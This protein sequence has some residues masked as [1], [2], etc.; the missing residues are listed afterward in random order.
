MTE[1]TSEAEK[2]RDQ[3]LARQRR[4]LFG[5]DVNPEEVIDDIRRHFDEELKGL[6]VV[7]RT[8][9]QRTIR[10]FEPQ[11]PIFPSEGPAQ[12]TGL[13]DHN[14]PGI[15]LI[16]FG[17]V[18]P[19]IC[20]LIELTIHFCAGVFFDPIPSWWH[21]ALVIF[22]P[23]GNALHI[24]RLRLGGGPSAGLALGFNAASL[25]IASFYAT[26]YAPLLLPGLLA[27]LYFGIG[28]LPLGPLFAL[29]TAYLLRRRLKTH[30]TISSAAQLKATLAGTT[31]AIIALGALEFRPA[32]TRVALEWADDVAPRRQQHG[33]QILRSV[34]DEETM[35]RACYERPRRFTNLA[36]LF[37]SRDNPLQ[38]LEARTIYFRVTGK[39]FNSQ[40]PPRLYTR[41]GRWEIAEEFSWESDDAQGGNAVEGRLRGLSLEDSRIDARIHSQAGLAYLEWTLQFRNHSNR[42]QEARTQ[43]LL[44]PDGL[45]SRLTLWINGEERE[46][47][48]AGRGHVRQAYENIVRQR[49]DPVLVTTQGKDRIL[50]QC[51]PVPPNGGK[52][53]TRIGITVPLQMLDLT[54]GTLLLP[55]MVERNFS[56]AH[57]LEHT[58]WVESRAPLS[59]PLTPLLSSSKGE[60]EFKLHGQILNHELVS[61]QAAIEVTRP[62]TTKRVWTRALDHQNLILQEIRQ[63]AALDCDRL[64]IVLDGSYG[65]GHSYPEIAKALESFPPDIE[66]YFLFASD[67][68]SVSP[69]QEAPPNPIAPKTLGDRVA[70]LPAVGG[71]DNLKW[72]VRA[73]DI[74]AAGETGAVLWIH[75]PQPVVLS[76]D[77]PLKQRMERSPEEPRLFAMQTVSGPNRILEQLGNGPL[78]SLPRFSS[79]ETDLTRWWTGLAAEEGAWSFHREMKIESEIDQS[80]IPEVTSHVRR[81]WAAEQIEALAGHNNHAKAIQLAQTHQLV[82][83]VSG[84]VVLE[85]KEQFQN[86]GLTPVNPGSVPMIPEPQTWLLLLLGSATLWG[87]R[88]R[89]PHGYS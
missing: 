13:P 32:I 11:P 3:F 69:S 31:V 35:L 75:G 36:S 30:L 59:S 58:L 63:S 67:H 41:N 5:A 16:L 2:E 15:P 62:E 52:M 7:T 47:A 65:M 27:T 83:S 6:S 45:V 37:I 66:L 21:V 73:W 43:I 54:R 77:Q 25:V 85:T 50:V 61:P 82:T 29:I 68:P 9:V 46:A 81:L 38:P 74:A 84:A 8:D 51:F 33:I 4:T 56:L 76:A 22:V 48:F 89:G 12:P 88:T 39:A 20:I 64:V 40:P 18:L 44:P 55:H 26:L 53:Q 23:L 80:A 72:L 71:Q 34:G 57:G 70:S 79:L 19:L 10:C 87:Y 49:R 86:A 42:Q 17:V 1:W 28:L 78:E 14:R 24:R 60:S